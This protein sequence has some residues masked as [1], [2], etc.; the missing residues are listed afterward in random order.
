MSGRVQGV[1][2]RATVQQAA[3]RAGV[4]GWVR[5]RSDGAVES[6]VQGP[7]EDVDE[8]VGVIRDGPAFASVDDASIED[9]DV[10]DGERDFAVRG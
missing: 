5:N 10:V 4:S 3:R 9:V 7:P 8:V 2:F 1:G 6:E